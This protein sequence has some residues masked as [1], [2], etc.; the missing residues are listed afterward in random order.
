V[1]CGPINALP[2]TSRWVFPNKK[3]NRINHLLR[4]LKGIAEVAKVPNA[5]LH[6]FRHTYATRLL[7][8]CPLSDG[9]IREACLL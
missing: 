6:K 1:P 3:G 5:T 9:A 7:E 2:Q 4:A 8:R